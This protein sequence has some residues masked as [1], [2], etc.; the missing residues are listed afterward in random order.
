MNLKTKN[1]NFKNV[2]VAGAGVLGSQIAWQTAFNGF[3]VVVYDA[4]EKGLEA[5]KAFH[6]QYA[7]L[8]K[9]ERGASDKE[10]E[11]TFARL[12]YT[13]NL[14]EAVKDCDI[15]SESVPEKLEIKKIFYNNLA[16]VAP[17]KTIFTTNSSS[18]LPS[19]FA[20]ETGRPSKFLALHFANGIWDANIGEVMGH[21]TTDPAIFN[22]VV[23]FAKA[24]KMVPII[25]KKEQP[26]YVINSLLIPFVASA[27][28]LL[29]TGVSDHES[30][31]KTWMISTGMKYGPFGIMDIV[32]LETVYNIFV[33]LSEKPEHKTMGD[34]AVFIKANF[35]NKGNLGVKTAKGFY[36]YP[37]PSYESDD[38]LI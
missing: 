2:T 3:N 5:G 20:N 34:L 12:S 28:G 38:F 8:F 6:Q 29:A 19:Q 36:S 33:G 14:G 37:N 22:Q 27:A 16:E 25:I 11:D 26:G 24:I 9:N 15:I 17:E 30:I 23:A 35:I 7:K 10:I 1:M 4:F 21:D 32:G 31:D 18:L 13:T